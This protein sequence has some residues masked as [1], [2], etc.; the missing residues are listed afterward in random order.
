M[1]EIREYTGPEGALLYG[2]HVVVIDEPASADDMSR[3]GLI[4]D[5][6]SVRD[7]MG[8]VYLVWKR[9]L[10]PVRG[11]CVCGVCC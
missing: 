8:S 6:V 11:K 9:A 4:G 3:Y 7:D 10:R 2:E 1:P 5:W